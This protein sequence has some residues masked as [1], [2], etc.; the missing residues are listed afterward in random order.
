[1]DTRP[2]FLVNPETGFLPR[3]EPVAV[4][5]EAFAPLERLL[6]NMPLKKKDGSPGLLAQN[7]F[8]DESVKIP[9]YTKQIEKIE[10]TG[11]LSALFRD[12]TFWASS[13]LLEPCHHNMLAA[14]DAHS[15]GL[16]RQVLPLNIASPLLLLSEKLGAKP[17]ME[18]A[19]SYALYNWKKV[20]PAGPVTYS[21]L[22]LVRSFSGEPSESGF[23]LVHV[24]MVAHTNKLVQHCLDILEHAR[25]RDREA[26][27]A[28][29]K[30]YQQTMRRIN[31]EMETMWKHSKPEDYEKFRTFIMGIKGQPMFPNGVHYERRDPKTNEVVKMGPF[32]FRGESGANDSII[33]T[34]DNLLQL[35]ESMPNN[36]LTEILRDFRTYRPV[37][38]NAWLTFVH[39]N[40]KLLGIKAYALADNQSAFHYLTI[41]DEVRDFRNRH[42]NFTKEYILRRSLH[43]VATGGSPIVTWLPNQL[44]VVLQGMEEVAPVVKC[45][46]L[47][48]AADRARCEEINKFITSQRS[49]LIREVEK[50]KV[51]RNA[52]C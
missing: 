21:N 32:E 22:E 1:M 16:G 26:F 9:D 43:P 38:H 51:E 39:E 10:D 3:K 52:A 30:G 19:L 44:A 50:L 11:L 42:W 20:N 17:F 28:A 40:A 34:C 5:P 36:P 4:L 6:Q 23:I 2:Q 33:P 24:S 35:T 31:T 15:F 49:M 12:Y 8:G 14:G 48:D 25:N 37:Q 29:L 41:L 45:E 47:K 46:E 27:N 7:K 18:Y 13:Y